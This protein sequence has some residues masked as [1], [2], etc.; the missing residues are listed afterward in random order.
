MCCSLGGF[1][2]LRSKSE[3][4]WDEDDSVSEFMW[5][6]FQTERPARCLSLVCCSAKQQHSFFLITTLHTGSHVLVLYQTPQSLLFFVTLK[7][8]SMF[9]LLILE[10]TRHELWGK[11]NPSSTTSQS[12][13]DPHDTSMT[14]SVQHLFIT[15]CNSTFCNCMDI[16]TLLF[17]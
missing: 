14:F 8:S 2:D 6:L 11:A 7:F 9:F 12:R 5:S 16:Q 10:K 1:V 4:K 15:Y 17:V 13:G 3:N